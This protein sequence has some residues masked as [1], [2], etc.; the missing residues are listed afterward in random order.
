MNIHMY[1]C[2]HAYDIYTYTYHTCRQIDIHL[3]ECRIY[4]YILK[5]TSNL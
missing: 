4:V 5:Y 2:I 3:H 1:K